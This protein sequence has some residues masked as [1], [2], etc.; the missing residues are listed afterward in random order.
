MERC[1]M[2]QWGVSFSDGEGD[3]IFKWRW[4]HHMEGDIGYHGRGQKNRKGGEAPPHAD[5]APPQL[6]ETL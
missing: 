2:F 3:F 5:N 1:F 6:W 4:G